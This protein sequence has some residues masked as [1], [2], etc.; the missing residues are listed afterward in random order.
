MPC[1]TPPMK[2][3]TALATTPPL[4]LKKA[5]RAQ[6]LAVPR[7]LSVMRETAM[8]TNSTS[9]V[10]PRCMTWPLPR[11]LRIPLAKVPWRLRHNTTMPPTLWWV[12]YQARR[13]T[14][15][16]PH[17]RQHRSTQWTRRSCPCV[18]K[19]TTPPRTL[20]VCLPVAAPAASSSASTPMAGLSSEKVIR[21]VVAVVVAVVVQ[22]VALVVAVVVVVVVVVATVMA[23]EA[24]AEPV[25]VVVAN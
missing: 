12:S 11:L 24:A 13:P 16:P 14:V 22:V 8:A 19:P 17:A 10:A 4:V 18:G 3:P 2:L 7:Q 5:V 15:A 1:L 25:S 21:V 6:W 9:V 20:S 23:V